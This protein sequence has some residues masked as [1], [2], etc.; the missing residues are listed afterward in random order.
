MTDKEP[1]LLRCG[2]VSRGAR[3]PHKHGLWWVEDGRPRSMDRT[4]VVS[5]LADT[6]EAQMAGSAITSV[7]QRPK[8]VEPCR[9]G[10]PVDLSLDAI[11]RLVTS[12]QMRGET[13]AYINS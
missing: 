2:R 7:L 11:S 12:A 3:C 9:C 10:V 13:V 1:V 5:D 6:L 4:H 8:L